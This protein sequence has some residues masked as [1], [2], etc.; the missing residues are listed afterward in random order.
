MNKMLL[1]HEQ[2]LA[3]DNYIYLE[4]MKHFSFQ[5]SAGKFKYELLRSLCLDDLLTLTPALCGFVSLVLCKNGDDVRRYSS[6]LFEV[7][8]EENTTKLDMEIFSKYLQR[9]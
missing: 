6:I 1:D 3:I 8:K 9:V 4:Q 5:E 2:S 7:S